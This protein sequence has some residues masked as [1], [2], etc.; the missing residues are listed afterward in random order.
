LKLTANISTGNSVGPHERGGLVE[1]FVMI[2]GRGIYGR[3]RD[4]GTA[5]DSSFGYVGKLALPAH[6][7]AGD[8]SRGV[9]IAA[10]FEQRHIV[11]I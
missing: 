7:R 8:T 9:R 2:K 6:R 11:A 5:E 10:T 3:K 1:E 4:A